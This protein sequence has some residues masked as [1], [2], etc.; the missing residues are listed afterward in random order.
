MNSSPILKEQ[1]SLGLFLTPNGLLLLLNG[2]DV[3][4]FLCWQLSGAEESTSLDRSSI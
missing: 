2:N 3:G 4:P 1:D